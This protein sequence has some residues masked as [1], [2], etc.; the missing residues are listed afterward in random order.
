MIRSRCSSGICGSR[1]D[2]LVEVKSPTRSR[3]PVARRAVAVVE[4]KGKSAFARNA[5][6]S[7]GESE[8]IRVLDVKVA[9]ERRADAR[10]ER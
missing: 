6:D 1:T 5:L 8:E 4:H 3:V 10:R 9:R 2:P 7:R